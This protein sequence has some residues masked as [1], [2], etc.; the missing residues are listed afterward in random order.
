VL[1]GDTMKA[2]CVAMIT[3]A[4]L[5]I[6]KLQGLRFAQKTTTSK[7]NKMGEKSWWR[8]DRCS[9][10]ASMMEAGGPTS[11][12]RKCVECVFCGSAQAVIMAAAG[13]GG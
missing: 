6:T 4:P 12:D 8:G 5:K 3:Y 1:L 10:F 7:A 2:P 13:P 9:L 11:S